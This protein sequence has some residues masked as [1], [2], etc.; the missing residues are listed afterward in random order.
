[1]E[2]ENGGSEEEPRGRVAAYEH[3]L[4]EHMRPRE[5]ERVSRSK[6]SSL[7][8]EVKY[9]PPSAGPTDK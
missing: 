6:S 1:M 2:R 3:E 4:D 9:L 5:R 7:M 8:A